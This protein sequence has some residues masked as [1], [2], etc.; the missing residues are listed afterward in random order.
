MVSTRN[1]S[2]SNAPR[3]PDPPG[4]ADSRPPG[5]AEAMQ[6]NTSEVEALRLVNQRLIEELEQLTRQIQHPREIHRTQ[7]G[8]NIPPQEGR[9]GHG[10]PRDAEA[11]A[12]SSQARGH[13][14]QLAPVEEENEAVYRRRGESV[15]PH[16]A[17]PVAGEQTWEQRFRKLQQ[18]LSRV[19]EVVKGRAPDTMDTLVQQTESP[20]TPEVLRYPLPAKFRMPQVEAFDGVK[21][22]V[23][24]LNTYKNQMELHGY[25][26]PVRCRAFATTLK[27]PAMA[28]FNRIPPSTISSFR[29]LSIAFVSHFIG[30]RTY[31]KPSYHL[32]TIKQGT[33][34]NLKSYVQRFNADSLKIDVLDEK[35]AV[36]AFIAGLRVQSKDLMFS[37]SKNPQANMAE[38]LAKAEKYINGEEALLSKKESSSARKEK[39]TTDQRR[40]WSPKRQGD[41]RKSPGRERERSPKRRGSLR[42]CLGPPQFERRRRYSPQRFIP[43]TAS[44]SQ[45][46]HEVRNEQFLRWPAQMKSNPATR[47]NT[48]YCEFHRDY[49]HRTDNCIQLRREIEYLI[50]RGYLRRFISPGSQAQ[51]QTQN[52]S[53]ASAQQPPPRQTTTQHQQPLGEIHVISGGFAGGGESSSARKAHLRSIRLTDMEEIQTVFKVPRVDTTITFF[54]SDLEGCKHPHDDPLVVRAIVANTTVHQVLVDNGSSAD[55]IFASAFDKMGIG[56]EKLEP[57]STHLRGFSGEKVL[58]LGSIQL[59][60]TLGEPPC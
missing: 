43:L 42:D 52:Q 27:G 60:L 9:H 26:D 11:E 59:V 24:H 35:F 48:K 56:R 57:V 58:P 17:P 8:H 37:I 23:D 15:E 50:Q 44:V 40:E 7:E 54:D 32:L 19:K 22:P 28:W 51:S 33:R 14:P 21:D 34:E 16:H 55:I 53:Q 47:D 3:M 46:L 39:G 13:A 41:Q 4:D 45:V 2:R 29:E 30:A 38:V 1:T 10:I 31:R 20:F 36:T 49:G 12:E 5:P 25:P 18:E 6:A